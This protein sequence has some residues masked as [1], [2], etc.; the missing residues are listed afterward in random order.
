MDIYSFIVIASAGGF[1]G[2]ANCVL[3]GGFALP[4]LDKDTGIWKPGWIGT[5]FVGALA[6]IIVAVL[7]GGE[8]PIAESAQ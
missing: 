5:V 4:Y 1:G 3:S 7:Y 2:I 6:A 8:Q